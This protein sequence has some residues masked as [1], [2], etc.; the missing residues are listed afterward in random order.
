MKTC[1][2]FLASSVA[3]FVSAAGSVWAYGPWLEKT[4]IG[5][6]ELSDGFSRGG[7]MGSDPLPSHTNA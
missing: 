1:K 6:V 4:P 7:A 5:G 2:E 3:F